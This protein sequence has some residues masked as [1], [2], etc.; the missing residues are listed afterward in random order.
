MTTLGAL[1]GL[2]LA[3]AQAATPDPQWLGTWELDL[4]KSQPDAMAGPPPKSVTLTFKDVG[5]G[6]RSGEQVVVLTDGKEAPRASA[7]FSTDG[8]PAPLTGFPTADT[9]SV[10][11]SDPRTEVVTFSKAGKV[12]QKMTTTLSADGK[13]RTSMVEST[14][15][16]GKSVHTTEIW[17][18]K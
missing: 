2:W 13:H 11:Y 14:D 9:V 5:G 6:K 18:K 16:D 10:S 4:S 1:A 3:S 12:V 17:N 7:T 8:T 15:K